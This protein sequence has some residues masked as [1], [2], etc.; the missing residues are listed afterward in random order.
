[1]PYWG[2][3]ALGTS[4]CCGCR[5]GSNVVCNRPCVSLPS[6]PMPGIFTGIVFVDTNG[7]MVQDVD[8]LGVAGVSVIITDSTGRL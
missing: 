2:F 1:M 7:D 8:E 5:R 4:P 6:I 3:C